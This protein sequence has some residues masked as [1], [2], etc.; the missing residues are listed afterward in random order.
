MDED[1][2]L[3]ARV[4]EE[5]VTFFDETNFHRAIH[6]S[7]LIVVAIFPQDANTNKILFQF[8]CAP[9]MGSGKKAES[10]AVYLQR[11]VD[12]KLHR[13]ISNAFREFFVEGV[14]EEVFEINHCN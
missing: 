13:E 3:D 9:Q 10:T 1:R 8:K 12:G 2:K 6:I 5:G 14:R 11:L 4:S 7:L